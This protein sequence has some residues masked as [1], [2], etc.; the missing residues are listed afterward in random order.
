MLNEN[1]EALSSEELAQ[2]SGGAEKQWYTRYRCS[3]GH[4][5]TKGGKRYDALPCEGCGTM[6]YPDQPIYQ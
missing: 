6:V 1:K 5:T 4:I 2:I 3:C